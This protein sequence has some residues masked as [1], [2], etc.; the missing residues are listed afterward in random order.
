[1]IF[2][3]LPRLGFSPQTHPG[4][5]EVLEFLYKF[6]IAPG[7]SRFRGKEYDAALMRNSD[8]LKFRADCARDFY[9]GFFSSA[10]AVPEAVHCAAL[11]RIDMLLLPETKIWRDP[12]ARAACAL[13]LEA[14]TFRES[15][16]ERFQ[17]ASP[18]AQYIYML[19]TYFDLA[20][21]HAL[22]TQTRPSR[23]RFENIEGPD[24]PRIMGFPKTPLADE[25]DDMARLVFPLIARLPAARHKPVLRIAT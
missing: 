10:N 4:V 3:L 9:H 13:C 5:K 2:D 16:P 22:L 7:L 11:A 21:S 19:E 15:N 17:K 23:D 6:N 12:A 24:H 25:I 8:Y 14:N 1:M 18:A 20:E